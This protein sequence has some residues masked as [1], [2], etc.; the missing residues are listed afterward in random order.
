MQLESLFKGADAQ[1]WSA[2]AGALLDGIGA[3]KKPREKAFTAAPPAFEP[4]PPSALAPKK[5]AP[6]EL[7]QSAENLRWIS[8]TR[9]AKGR[10]P[11]IIEK[12]WHRLRAA[13]ADPHGRLAR[14]LFPADATPL[15]GRARDGRGKDQRERA[16]QAPA[17]VNACNV[18]SVII[19][20]SD[21]RSGI[22]AAPPAKGR[23][24]EHKSWSDIHAI[25]FGATDVPELLN[26]EKRLRRAIQKLAALGYIEITQIR[27]QEQ[28]EWR[29]RVAV[30]RVSQ[31]LFAK[32]GLLREHLGTVAALNKARDAK[33]KAA[34]E[35]AMT[36]GDRA[37]QA[38]IQPTRRADGRAGEPRELP[39]MALEL[40]RKLGLR[41]PS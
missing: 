3:G 36:A 30:K 16:V 39:A 5:W 26:R 33:A 25:A 27:K 9:P 8:W 29:S 18:L 19:G 28:G 1:A 40:A 11:Q 38:L 37:R 17:I 6:I 24:W 21:L 35:R 20:W 15:P 23:G 41:P 4:A 14:K 13:A 7:A 31:M 2:A 12:A 32:L 10:W 34:R 22:V